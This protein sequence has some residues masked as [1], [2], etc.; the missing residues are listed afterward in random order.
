MSAE[1][2]EWTSRWEADGESILSGEVPGTFHP[3]EVLAA[4]HREDWARRRGVVRATGGVGAGFAALLNALVVHPWT[5]SQLGGSVGPGSQGPPAGLH[6][7]L[8]VVAVVA[9]AAGALALWRLR[10]Q[11]GPVVQSWFLGGLLWGAGTFVMIDGLLD[12]ALL[13]TLQLGT[14][15]VWELSGLALVCLGRLVLG[16]PRGHSS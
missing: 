4:R 13:R 16:R 2:P 15:V 6:V 14:Y 10:R 9:L 3:E 8:H 11:S 1:T 12:R 7:A 5:A